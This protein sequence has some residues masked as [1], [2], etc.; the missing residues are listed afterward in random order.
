MGEAEDNLEATT[1]AFLLRGWR[2][3]VGQRVM[4]HHL[5]RSGQFKP[6]DRGIVLDVGL[7]ND[8]G[9][10]VRFDHSIDGT[11]VLELW[12]PPRELRLLTIVEQVGEI[13]AHSDPDP[14][15][16]EDLGYP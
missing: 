13:G 1:R 6:G 15:D 14:G 10:M 8:R 4:V 3:M 9:V 16:A 2:G 11:H 7:N 12:V 5:T